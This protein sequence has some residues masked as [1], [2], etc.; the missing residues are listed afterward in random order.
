VDGEEIT[1]AIVPVFEDEEI[2][3]VDVTMG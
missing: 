3:R 1:G 2:H